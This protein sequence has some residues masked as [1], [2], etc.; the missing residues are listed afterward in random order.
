M[1][2]HNNQNHKHQLKIIKIDKFALYTFNYLTYNYEI[3]AILAANTLLD[4]LK[5]YTLE[6]LLKQVYL[7]AL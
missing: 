2:Q 4:L 3:N 1:Q 6:K 5:Y 7:K